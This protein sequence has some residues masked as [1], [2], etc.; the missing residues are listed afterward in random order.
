MGISN[1]CRWIF[2]E[3]KLNFKKRLINIHFSNLPENRGSG[4]LSWDIM[5]IK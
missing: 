1:S 4:G 2:N 3:N 5:T